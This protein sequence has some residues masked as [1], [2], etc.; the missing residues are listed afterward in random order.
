MGRNVLPDAEA[1]AST[2][3]SPPC[4]GREEESMVEQGSRP[5]GRSLD[6]GQDSGHG[7]VMAHASGLW[8]AEAPE[9]RLESLLLLAA[10]SSSEITQATSLGKVLGFPDSPGANQVVTRG[11][12]TLPPLMQTQGRRSK[13][14]GCL[15]QCFS[16]PVRAWESH[17][18]F[19]GWRR[20]GGLVADRMP[21][22]W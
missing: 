9:D 8:D 17:F 11:M 5:A 19:A 15:G 10:D 7:R 2:T 16:F 21:S 4:R 20:L 3:R 12:G 22:T 13:A 14:L 1:A 18:S 6:H